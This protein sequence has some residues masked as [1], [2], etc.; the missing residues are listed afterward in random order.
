MPDSVGGVDAIIDRL[1]GESWLHV[2]PDSDEQSRSVPLDAAVAAVREASA[3]SLPDTDERARKITHGRHCIC[4]A[5][6]AEDW[7][8]PQL[9]PCGM[10]GSSC[11]RVYDPW[12]GAGD[13]APLSPSLHGQDGGDGLGGRPPA[14]PHGQDEASKR[15][16]DEHA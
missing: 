6:G 13:P 4:S 14:V 9:A 15:N 3:P 8:N 10:H 2:D 16:P 1:R 12:G 11:P 5:C 7:T